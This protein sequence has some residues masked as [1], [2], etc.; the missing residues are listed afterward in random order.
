MTSSLTALRPTTRHL[1]VLLT[2]VLITSTAAQAQVQAWQRL[3]GPFGGRINALLA[4]G[5][6]VYASTGS[7]FRSVDGGVTWTRI[8]VPASAGSTARSSHV[9]ALSRD[10]SGGI[11]A[12]C[13]YD[14]FRSTD[15]GLSWLAV[16]GLRPV[17]ASG[18]VVGPDGTVFTTRGGALYRLRPG[19][20][21]SVPVGLSSPIAVIGIAP[22]GGSIYAIGTQYR[23]WRSDDGGRSWLLVNSTGD[24]SLPMIR[25]LVILTGW[26]LRAGT[27]E[28][29]VTS[30]DGGQTWSADTTSIRERS[31]TSLMIREDFMYAGTDLFG[32][33]RSS[34]GGATWS[35]IPY[36]LDNPSIWALADDARGRLYAGTT[37]G[38]HHS[39]DAGSTWSL[40]VTG[41]TGVAPRCLMVAPSGHLFLGAESGISRSTDLGESWSPVN[42]GLSAR[43]TAS[44]VL[45]SAGALVALS[46]HGELFRS[47]DDGNSWQRAGA[48]D[49]WEW[50]WSIAV[51][52]QGDLV[53]VARNTSPQR[54]AILR[55]TDGGAGWQ[56]V[57]DVLDPQDFTVAADGSVIAMTYNGGIYR[58]TS[59][60]LTWTLVAPRR[61]IDELTSI[62][63][64]ARGGVFAGGRSY[65]WRSV[66]NGQIW[67]QQYLGQN[68]HLASIAVARDGSIVT[69]VMSPSTSAMRS[70]NRGLD[71][72]DMS[73]GLDGEYP[74]KLAFAATGTVFGTLPEGLARSRNRITSGV[75]GERPV[76]GLVLDRP[77]PHPVRGES[78][79]RFSIAESSPVR[80][81]LFDMRGTEVRVLL[82][83][84]ASPGASDVALDATG[85]AAGVY[86]LRLQTSAGVRVERIVVE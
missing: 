85:L 33:F 44:I 70:T 62:G 47:T 71:W 81:S 53:V 23:V 66:D 28:G 30:D 15:D 19:A 20:T 51:T 78:S 36:G 75:G 5:E 45:D 29:V 56:E 69:G 25:T 4:D 40:G 21:S 42:Y 68:V 11:L 72:V 46:Q 2:I 52:S 16:D 83:E 6:A 37:A 35:Q 59:N 14:L 7:L 48:V 50:T 43:Q 60:G 73:S 22:Q 39:E 1:A 3:P 57:L 27:A 58:S 34:D 55:S 12:L 31:I 49:G 38:V 26:R 54:A 77:Q 24:T 32:P 9:R 17:G 74:T 76:T 13:N 61:G 10:S 63:A 84:F 18:L 41:M 82:D 79:V 65:L 86:A 80:L 8:V 64:D 67:I